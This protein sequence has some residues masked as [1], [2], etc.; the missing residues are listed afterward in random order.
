[1][2]RSK[3][4]QAG[5]LLETLVAYVHARAARDMNAMISHRAKAVVAGEK[6]LMLASPRDA[7][8]LERVTRFVLNNSE[9][10]PQL[11]SAGVEAAAQVLRRWVRGELRGRRIADAY[12]PALTVQLEMREGQ[13]S[14]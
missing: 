10:H 8:H 2:L 5:I 13:Q 1:M 3:R 6:L 14:S 9:A 12:E 4:D 11:V 7:P